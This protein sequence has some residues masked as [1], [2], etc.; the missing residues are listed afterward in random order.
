VIST[1]LHLRLVGGWIGVS[2]GTGTGNGQQG[3]LPHGQ[4]SHRAHCSHRHWSH[5]RFYLAVPLRQSYRGM[6]GFRRGP[7]VEESRD[8]GPEDTQFGFDLAIRNGLAMRR[9]REDLLATSNDV[10]VGLCV[11]PEQLLS[12]AL[13]ESRPGLGLRH[14]LQARVRSGDPSADGSSDFRSRPEAGLIR[15]SILRTLQRPNR[16]CIDP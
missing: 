9:R 14:E 16:S 7:T 13:Y 4:R 15:S 6:F 2:T 1:E 3:S 12:E 8:S 5:W 11:L 10:V